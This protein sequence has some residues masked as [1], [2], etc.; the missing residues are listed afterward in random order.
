MKTGIGAFCGFRRGWE[1]M[2]EDGRG[3]ERRGEDRRGGERCHFFLR[4]ILLRAFF[5]S[6]WFWFAA[7]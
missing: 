2:G 4:F 3:Q 7:F 1:R 5:A 6:I